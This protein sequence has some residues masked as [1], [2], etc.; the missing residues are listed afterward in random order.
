[1]QLQTTLPLFHFIKRVQSF[2]LSMRIG[3]PATVSSEGTKT[4]RFCTMLLLWFECLFLE[5]LNQE[6][7]CFLHDTFFIASAFN[8]NAQ[9]QELLPP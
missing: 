4:I 2:V 7:E 1:M 8:C 3:V 9:L 6:Q 5:K